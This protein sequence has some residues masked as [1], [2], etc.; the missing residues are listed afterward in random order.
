MQ[1]PGG[2]A[3]TTK[4]EYDAQ[5]RVTKQLRHGR[6]DPR[7]HVLVRHGH[8]HLSGPSGMG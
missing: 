8:G 4:T 1:D 5:G 2:L 7:D 6:R 3:I